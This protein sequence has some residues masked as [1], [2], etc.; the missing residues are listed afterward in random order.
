MNRLRVI[1]TI[2]SL[3]GLLCLVPEALANWASGHDEHHGHPVHAP[4]SHRVGHHGHYGVPYQVARHRKQGVPYR[5]ARHRKHRVPYRVARHRTRGVPYRVARRRL[6]DVPYR[7]ARH[8]S[9]R[10]GYFGLRVP[11]TNGH[12]D[13][14][15]DPYGNQR[16]PRPGTHRRWVA[17]GSVES[18][19]VFDRSRTFHHDSQVHAPGA[20][21]TVHEDTRVTHEEHPAAQGAELEAVAA[22]DQRFRR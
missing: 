1:A 16:R 11:D 17:D 5:I 8:R 13:V 20:S 18:R 12:R 14:S 21:Q 7:I 19:E 6:D 2:V 10:F 9:H 15:R 3:V 4:R 22:K